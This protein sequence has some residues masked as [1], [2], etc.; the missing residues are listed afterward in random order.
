MVRTTYGRK[1]Y[2]KIC[3]DIGFKNVNCLPYNPYW[4]VNSDPKFERK[5]TLFFYDLHY[6]LFK[7]G[8]KVS[9]KTWSLS[10]L[11]YLLVAEK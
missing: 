6:R 7:K 8:S 11:C 3:I 9:M 2:E 1:Y 5:F 4:K 10:E